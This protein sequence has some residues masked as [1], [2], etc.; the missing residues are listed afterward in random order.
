MKDFTLI[1]VDEQRDFYHPTGTLYVHGGELAVSNTAKFIINNFKYIKKV[2]PTVDWH[3]YNEE[4]FTE[5]NNNWPMH[6][7]QFSEGAGI[8]NEVIR[9]CY[10]TNTPMEIFIKGNAPG[11]H[12]EYGAFEKIGTYMYDNGD[13]DIITNNRN[14][15]SSVHIS[16]ENVVVC[17]IAGDYCVMNT[18]K[19]LL[20]YNGPVNMNISVFKDGIASIDDGTTI[21]NFIASHNLKEITL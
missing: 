18:I 12:T 7:G 9:A 5:P 17:G 8:A 21:N 6:C 2:I 14:N 16:T 10:I 13:I 19:N 15:D 20:K 11:F 1:I 3:N 4:S